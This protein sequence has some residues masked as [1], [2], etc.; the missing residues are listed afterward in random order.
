MAK[1]FKRTQ[2]VSLT[3]KQKEA[4]IS[5]LDT[6]RWLTPTSGRISR[7]RRRIINEANAL[8]DYVNTYKSLSESHE[9]LQMTHDLLKEDPDQDLQK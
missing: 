7:K 9:E 1:R 6:S 5:E 8:K 2:G 4:R 3:S